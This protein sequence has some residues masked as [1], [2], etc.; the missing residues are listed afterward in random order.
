MTVSGKH[1]LQQTCSRQLGITRLKRECFR[2]LEADSSLT[3][4]RLLLLLLSGLGLD[5]RQDGLGRPLRLAFSCVF[6]LLH[7][8]YGGAIPAAT[9]GWVWR[10]GGR[11]KER[12]RYSK[13]KP[14][15]ITK[16]RPVVR[17]GS[18]VSF[19]KKIKQN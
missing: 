18:G 5:R 8:G 15:S 11:T 14:V 19:S 1:P 6:A 4:F 2:Q 9:A 16:P 17:L 10:V 7:H 3:R 12:L 13:L